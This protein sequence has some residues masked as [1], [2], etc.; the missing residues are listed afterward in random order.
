MGTSSCRSSAG[1]EPREQ[2][3][4]ETTVLLVRV[5]QLCRQ[6]ALFCRN[7]KEHKDAEGGE[8]EQSAVQRHHNGSTQRQQPGAEIERIAQVAV[9]PG[10]NQSFP[11]QGGIAHHSVSEIGRT[12]YT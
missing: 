8:K 10:S 3:G 5:S 9:G 2:A 1:C 4:N 12:P 6:E 7:E 11:M